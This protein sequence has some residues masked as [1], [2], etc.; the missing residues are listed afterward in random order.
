MVWGATGRLLTELIGAVLA[1]RTTPQPRARGSREG[2]LAGHDLSPLR[3]GQRSRSSVLHALFGFARAP[4]GPGRPSPS[5]CSP[6]YRTGQAQGRRAPEPKVDGTSGCSRSTCS[7]RP[8]CRTGLSRAGHV[9]RQLAAAS[10]PIARGTRRARRR[11]PL[12]AVDRP[13]YRPAGAAR[14]AAQPEREVG[15]RPALPFGRRL[16]ARL[17]LPFTWPERPA[18]GRLTGHL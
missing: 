2:T 8:A 5:S 11:R 18:I 16:V 13:F 1:R 17:S 9:W 10:G 4:A 12:F 15:R 6:G 14:R 3:C 7:R